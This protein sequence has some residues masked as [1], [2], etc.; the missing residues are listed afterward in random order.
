MACPAVNDDEV[1]EGLRL[2]VQAAVAAADDFFHRTEV[3][4]A[5]KGFDL[6]AAVVLAVGLAVF[7]RD[8]GGDAEAA[9]NV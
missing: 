5:D 8:H 7:E 9:G 6:E 3:V 4:V 1:G 2:V